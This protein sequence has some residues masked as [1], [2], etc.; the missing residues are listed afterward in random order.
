MIGATFRLWKQSGRRDALIAR[1]YL[2]KHS[3]RNEWPSD[4]RGSHDGEAT[5]L[6]ATMGED[7]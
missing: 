7:I 5:I 1:A 6:P 2:D 3:W 4:N